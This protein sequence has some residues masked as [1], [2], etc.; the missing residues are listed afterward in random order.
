[1][2]DDGMTWVLTRHVHAHLDAA[3]AAASTN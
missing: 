2:T 1:M 3:A